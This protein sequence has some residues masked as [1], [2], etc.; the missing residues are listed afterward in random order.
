MDLKVIFL[1]TNGW[2][3]TKTGNTICTLI[4][5]EKCNIIL[6]AG[7]GLVKADKYLDNKKPSYLLLSHIH[8]DH[9][10]GLHALAKFKFPKG[11]KIILPLEY[12]NILRKYIAQPFTVPIKN[13]GFKLEIVGAK[14]R[15]GFSDVKVTAGKLVHTCL[16]LGY[17]MEIGKKTISYCTDTGICPQALKLSEKA[18]LLITE[19]ALRYGQDDE[20][21][22]HLDPEHAATLA[23]QSQA[24]R[25][26]MTHFD[27]NNYPLLSM[28]KKAQSYARRVFKKSLAA[29]DGLKITV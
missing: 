21:W 11:L 20:G 7:M 29:Y 13:L 22:P 6:D 14:N 26:I 10:A 2:F 1:G 28:R 15:F 12:K 17:R 4:K 9:I 19:C 16:C 3:D 5:T 23:R 24:K 8:L 18:D 27:A 25:L